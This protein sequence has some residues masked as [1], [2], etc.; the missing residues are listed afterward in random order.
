MQNPNIDLTVYFRGVMFYKKG[1]ES[2]KQNFRIHCYNMRNNFDIHP[3]YCST[4][5][6]QRSVTN[7]G[8]KLFKKLPL[9]IKQ[10]GSYK[11]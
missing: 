2:L 6:Y 11:D 4:I 7:M 9:Q 3:C 1:Q 5:L 10:L 8:I